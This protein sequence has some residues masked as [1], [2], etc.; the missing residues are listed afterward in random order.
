MGLTPSKKKEFAMAERTTRHSAR[1]SLCALEEYLRRHAFFVPLY[2][3]VVVYRY[4]A[5]KSP[6]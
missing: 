3:H 4:L 5:D 2:H 6:A 1:A